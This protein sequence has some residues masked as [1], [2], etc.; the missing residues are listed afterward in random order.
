MITTCG[1]RV[2]VNGVYPQP[3]KVF[4]DTKLGKKLCSS[5]LKSEGTCL[6]QTRRT[7]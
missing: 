6:A 3:A 7:Y 5:L 2:V 1:G 4:G